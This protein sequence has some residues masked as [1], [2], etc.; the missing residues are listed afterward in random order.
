MSQK[1]LDVLLAPATWTDLTAQV[2]QVGKHLVVLTN[3]SDVTLGRKATAPTSGVAVS[4]GVGVEVI[5]KEGDTLNLWARSTAGGKI[6]LMS[7]ADRVI[8]DGTGTV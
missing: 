8:L 6:T 4:A 2:N 1:T 7:L 5:I 3:R